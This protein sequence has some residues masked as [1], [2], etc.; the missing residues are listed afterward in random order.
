MAFAAVAQ[1]LLGSG[2]WPL[3]PRASR[4]GMVSLV[5]VRPPLHV[6]MAG[7]GAGMT[8]PFYSNVSDEKA[9][10]WGGVGGS[11]PHAEALAL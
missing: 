5:Q 4:M 1:Q 8:L 11:T 9:W 7:R 6:L 3:G 2:R 10:L